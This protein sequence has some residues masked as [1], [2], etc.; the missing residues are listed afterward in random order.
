MTLPGLIMM[1]PALSEVVVMPPAPV[2]C[3]VLPDGMDLDVLSSACTD[4][5]NAPAD[6]AAFTNDVVASPAIPGSAAT[7]EFT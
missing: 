7:V 3:T 6:T 4:N 2:N 5:T 1:L